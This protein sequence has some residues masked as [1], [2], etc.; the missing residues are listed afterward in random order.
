MDDGIYEVRDS[1]SIA[2]ENGKMI[3]TVIISQICK[4][5]RMGELPLDDEIA[6]NTF[7]PC[8]EDFSFEFMRAVNM[9]LNENNKE[10]RE[11]IGTF[12]DNCEERYI[13]GRKDLDEFSNKQALGGL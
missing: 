10:A 13:A 4:D 8:F 11:Y 12:I 7:V 2:L 9:K 5:I 3:M 6:Q 1:G